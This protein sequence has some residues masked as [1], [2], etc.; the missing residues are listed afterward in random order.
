MSNGLIIF[1]YCI[2]CYGLSN[3]FVFG[4][5]WFHIF[6]HIRN[7]ASRISEH[8]GKLF[9]CM[10]CFSSNAGIFLSLID[11][12]LIPQIAF[13]PF[14]I[15]LAGTG[16]WWLALLFDCCFTGGILWIIHHIELFFENIAEGNINND[17]DNNDIIQLND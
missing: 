2:T 15:L 5:G 9:Q 10:M 3:L 13:T 4:D 1:L 14:N 8:F 17:E 7:I 11:W 12:F 6:S 16:L